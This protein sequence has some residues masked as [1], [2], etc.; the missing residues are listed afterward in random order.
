MLL[1]FTVESPWAIL[2]AIT[3]GAFCY[4]LCMP[5]VNTQ[6]ANVV[7]PKQRA[8]AYALAV[9]ILHLLGDTGAPLLFGGYA[10]SVGK[11]RALTAFSFVLLPAAACCFAASR[12]AARDEAR[13]A[14]GVPPTR[15]S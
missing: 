11:E 3:L 5:A 13:F 15:P 8:M 12:W 6:I 4:F 10:D 2:P 9:F 1:G 14:A 7:S